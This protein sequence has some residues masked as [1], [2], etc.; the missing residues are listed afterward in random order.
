MSGTPVK[1]HYDNSTRAEQR[2]ETRRRVVAA[3]REAF[4]EQ[5]FSGTTMRV[6]ADRAG[7]SV[8]TIYK[9]FGSKGGLAR[10]VVDAAI[11][12]DEEQVAIVDRPVASEIAGAPDAGE[13]LRRY[14]RHARGIYERLGPLTAVL[15]GARAGDDE[16]QEL[17]KT[18]DEQ[19]LH[20]ASLLAR[21][22]ER[23]GQL[24]PELDEQ[25]IRDVIWALNS[26]ELHTLLVLDRGW[27]PDEYE[28]ML[29]EHLTVLIVGDN[30]ESRRSPA[31]R[32]RAGGR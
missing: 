18:A 6:V 16:L 28:Q 22:L 29:I 19:R 24:R 14:A 17:R 27:S 1:R 8:E 2:R 15:L 23:T 20:A 5:S 11:A 12:G 9:G 25:R 32:R 30:P 26:P 13:M 10:A 7:V 31:G 3:A 21:A 4:I